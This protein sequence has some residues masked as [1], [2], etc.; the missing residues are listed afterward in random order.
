ML[1]LLFKRRTVRKFKEDKIDKDTIEKI[2]KAGLLAPSSKDKKPVEFVIVED[3]DTMMRLGKC[4]SKGAN[5][6]GTAACAIAVIADSD[7]S[8]VWIEDASIASILIQLEAE[9]L[10]LGSVWIQMRKRQSDSGESETEVRKV[11]NIPENYGVL[12]IV[13]LGYKDE[14]KPH[15]DEKNL[16][17]SKVHFEKF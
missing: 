10:G 11:L 12:S 6:L 17:L 9:A 3:R 13:A 8:D 4:K 15:Y 7:L 2:I 16:N 5:G 1:D 14:E